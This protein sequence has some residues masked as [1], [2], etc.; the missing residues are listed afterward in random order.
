M[1]TKRKMKMYAIKKNLRFKLRWREQCTIVQSNTEISHRFIRVRFGRNSRHT[2]IKFGKTWT[3]LSCSLIMAEAMYDVKKCRSI[4]C[5]KSLSDE[6]CFTVSFW[7][8]CC[9]CSLCCLL[10]YCCGFFACWRGCDVTNIALA[11][12]TEAGTLD[13]WSIETMIIVIESGERIMP[14]I[15]SPTK[16]KKFN[17]KK[18][19]Y[20]HI[21][22]M[23]IISR[24]M[25]K[26]WSFTKI[27]I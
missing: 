22:E 5:H 27:C 13:L 26:K 16:R 1:K 2:L 3:N 17:W 8:C 12:P 25:I 10:S 6:T 20:I 4:C 24:I 7:G 14:P 9:C 19:G 15:P 21:Y 23:Y 18:D 11:L